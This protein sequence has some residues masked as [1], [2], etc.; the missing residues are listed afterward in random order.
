MIIK[1]KVNKTIEEFADWFY[2]DAQILMG[3]GALLTYDAK[4][5]LKYALEPY[6]TLSITMIQPL[7]NKY[8]YPRFDQNPQMHRYPIWVPP[9]L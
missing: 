7:V 5:A 1:I 9:P 8:T 4:T 3:C 2:Y 6:P